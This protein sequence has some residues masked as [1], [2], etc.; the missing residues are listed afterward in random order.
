MNINI[1]TNPNPHPHTER[2]TKT[3]L[4]TSMLTLTLPILY[5]ALRDL[6]DDYYTNLP[7]NPNADLMFS[8]EGLNRK[9]W[10]DK[11]EDDGV[12][13]S[14][15]DRLEG[16]LRGIAWSRGSEG[17]MGG[18]KREYG[19]ESEFTIKNKTICLTSNNEVVELPNTRIFEIEDACIILE[20]MRGITYEKLGSKI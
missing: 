3:T 6:M 11:M 14:R 20:E 13:E 18:I 16:V 8:V 10:E 1:N 15:L 12:D 19:V 4:P 2:L 17:G 7:T 5:K 9:F